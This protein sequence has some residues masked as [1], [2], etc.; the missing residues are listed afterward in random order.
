[1]RH[2]LPAD[3]WAAG[4]TLY[5]FIYRLFPF[6]ELKDTI[7]KNL[8]DFISPVV[9]KGAAPLIEAILEVILKDDIG[10]DPNTRP[11][12]GPLTTIIMFI[13]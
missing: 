13:L 12:I 3:I 11:E 10:K 1:M 7:N 8:P 5:T 9:K 4:V 6:K 2:H